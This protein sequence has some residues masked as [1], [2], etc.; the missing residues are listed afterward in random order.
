[1][2][3]TVTL[4]LVSHTNVGKTTLARTLLRRDVGEVLDQA[5]VTESNDA[6]ELISANDH[7][8][9]LWDTPGFGD[10]A[11]LMRRLRQ[12]SQPVGWFLH[13]VWDR[14]TDRPQWCNQKAIR[15]IQEDADVVIY[16]VNASEEPEDAGYIP[17]ELDLLTWID[18]PVLLLLNQ[19]GDTT[20]ALEERWREFA[21]D[22]PIIGDVIRLDAFTRSWVQESDMLQRVADLLP[23]NKQRAMLELAQAWNERN[24]STYRGSCK[25][26]AR[27]LAEQAIDSESP[28]EQTH[29]QGTS[30]A[31]RLA[32]AALKFSAIDKRRAMAALNQRLD[33]NMVKL[34]DQLIT[35]H[36][37]EGASAA[38][39]DDELREFEVKRRIP[40]NERSGAVAGAV[41]SGAVGGLGADVATGGMSMGTGMV[42][43]AI[44]GALG[45]S[46]LAK[47]YRLVGGFKQPAV[48]WSP[49]FLNHLFR[50]VL[51]RYFAVSHYGRGRGDYR[52]ID[53]NL[54]WHDAI[55]RAFQTRR[56]ALERIWDAAGDDGASTDAI[57]GRLERVVA[58]TT[59]AALIDIHPTARRA[60]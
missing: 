55:D 38:R 57:A 44:M 18:R 17:L 40:L 13:Q 46:A 3:E 23:D 24:L 56:Q 8:L 51:L 59:R 15:N 12:E 20:E 42:F 21:A 30:G 50:A 28:D 4:S 47:G 45:G 34:M 53:G 27:F 54:A 26:I 10:T 29:T 6:H 7:T 22:W 37:L 2:A 43:G 1:M 36:G 52:D 41:I 33:A 39:I 14:V 35:H 49:I 31:I 11:R 58:D 19:T 9:K 25:Q 48:R 16:L 5:H 32:A 60:L